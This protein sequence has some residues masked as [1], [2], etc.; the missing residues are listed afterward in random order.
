MKILCAGHR[1]FV[2]TNLLLRLS[3]FGHEVFG[4]DVGDPWP[5]ANDFGR[6]INLAG[7]ADVDK[8]EELPAAAIRTNVE[9]VAR[10]LELGH[11]VPFVQMSTQAVARGDDT[12]YAR[13]KRWAEEL[14][15]ADSRA[16]RVVRASNIFGP[17]SWHKS[18]V[19]P[20]FMRQA[21]R[22]LELEVLANDDTRDFVYIDVVCDRILEALEP[23]PSPLGSRELPAAIA[24]VLE[25]GRAHYLDATS[26]MQ[27]S[28]VA[29]ADCITHIARELEPTNELEEQLRLTYDWFVGEHARLHKERGNA[30]ND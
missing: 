15:Y 10:L 4:Y 29:L 13:T 30:R 9:L 28:I 21:V 22:G 23:Q 5:S 19:V 24:D 12:M 7:V 27:T 3:N 2:G 17:Y 11:G 25:A 14:V 16:H 18:S 1:G 6:I 20:A 8:C 26:G